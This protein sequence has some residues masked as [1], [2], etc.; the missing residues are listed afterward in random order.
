MEPRFAG[1]A[2][3]MTL[4]LSGRACCAPIQA[5]VVTTTIGVAVNELVRVLWMG[6]KRLHNHRAPRRYEWRMRSLRSGGDAELLSHF[7]QFA[8]FSLSVKPLLHLC[9][10]VVENNKV[11]AAH[12]KARQMVH[13]VFCVI[14]VLVNDKGSP[15][16]VRRIAHPNL[17]DRPKFAKYVVHLLRRDFERQVAHIQGAVHLGREAQARALRAA[18]GG[19]ALHSS[20]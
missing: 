12:I 18:I 10:L 5:I 3:A 8:L 6:K 11:A 1:A 20:S 16:R 19:H 13:S 17:P 4:L 7:C 14:D 15:A 9:L 2:R